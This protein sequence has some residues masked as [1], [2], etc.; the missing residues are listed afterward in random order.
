MAWSNGGWD[1]VL[2]LAIMKN[3]FPGSLPGVLAGMWLHSPIHWEQLAAQW[4][5]SRRWVVCVC[6]CGGLHGCAMESA[7]Q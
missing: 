3:T 7:Q 1:A 4:M 5:P 2:V 6:V